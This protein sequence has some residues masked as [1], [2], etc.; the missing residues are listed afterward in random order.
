[1]IGPELG[2]KVNG[3]MARVVQARD[4]ALVEVQFGLLPSGPGGRSSPLLF[5]R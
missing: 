3:H 1:V 4:G 5:G 2:G